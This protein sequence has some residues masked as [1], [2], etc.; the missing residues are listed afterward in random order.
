ML[1]YGTVWTHLDAGKDWMEGWVGG[2]CGL[3]SP[4]TN[5]CT[6]LYCRTFLRR[7]PLCS[8][9]WNAE[10]AGLQPDGELLTGQLQGQVS[11]DKMIHAEANKTQE[12][13]M[14]V[15]AET[16]SCIQKTSLFGQEST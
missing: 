8:G 10:E 4:Y 13:F 14:S 1:N 6:G 16:E 15:Q 3:L 2:W 7:I 11:P 12:T 9:V 5:M